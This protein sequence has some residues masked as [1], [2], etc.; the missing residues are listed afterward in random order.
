MPWNVLLVRQAAA[1]GFGCL[2]AGTYHFT[3]NRAV[4]ETK[5]LLATLVL[6]T[7]LIAMISSVIGDN[8]ARA[9][10]LV[11]ALSIVRF[12]TVVQ[13]TRD[14]AFVIYSVGAGMAVGT[15]H[16]L[17]ALICAPFAA[18][19]AFA[20]RTTYG[21]AAGTSQ[22]LKLR[23]EAETDI[24]AL[25]DALGSLVETVQP[26]GIATAKQGFVYDLRYRITLRNPQAAKVLIKRLA[27][28]PELILIELDE[29]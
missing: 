23:V 3:R 29:A 21:S 27:T 15:G 1:F 7:V 24:D 25:E 13:D 14:T 28:R 19:A 11:G 18:L 20:F 9:F 22:V 4:T 12:R 5:S 8:V 2:V 17:V 16:L 6:L 10:A 26:I